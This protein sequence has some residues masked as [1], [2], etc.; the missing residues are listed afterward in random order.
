I[1]HQLNCH[2]PSRHLHFSS[3]ALA[4]PP[5]AFMQMQQG[6]LLLLHSYIAAKTWNDLPTHL[7]TALSQADFGK[8]QDL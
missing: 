7:R 2:L 5:P 4:H 3:L 1:N 6:P 8:T